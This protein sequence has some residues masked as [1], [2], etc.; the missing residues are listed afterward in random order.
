ME[1]DLLN[2]VSWLQ[3]YT[4]RNVDCLVLTSTT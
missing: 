1:L 4:Y 2:C 3:L